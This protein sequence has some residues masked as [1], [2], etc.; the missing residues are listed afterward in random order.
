M[1]KIGRIILY[2]LLGSFVLIQFFRVQKNVSEDAVP[3]DFLQVHSDM[4]KN[5][6]QNFRI[7]CYDCHSN[8]TNYPWYAL[9]APFS[10][11]IDQH[12]RNGKDEHNFNAYDS[13]GKRQ[14]IAF[15]DQICEVVSDSSMPP[16]NYLMLH[17]D[18]ALSADEILLICNWTETEAIKL[19]RK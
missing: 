7:S 13:L 16:Q 14:K 9:V 2:M 3:H 12:I 15:L 5:L 17:S 10:W 6:Q 8:N 1:K 18:A 19:L 4:P 11:V